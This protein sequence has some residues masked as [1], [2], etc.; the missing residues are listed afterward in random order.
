MQEG[1]RIARGQPFRVRQRGVC[2][3]LHRIYFTNID[4]PLQL[5][6]NLLR[7]WMCSRYGVTIPPPALIP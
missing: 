7:I 6:E 1:R 4:K 5:D 3:I 2:K